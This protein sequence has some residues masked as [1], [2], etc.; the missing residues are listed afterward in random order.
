MHNLSQLFPGIQ[1]ICQGEQPTKEPHFAHN[2]FI[3]PEELLETRKS[4]FLSASMLQ[5][6]ATERF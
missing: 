6:R 1:I 4:P 5:E 3:Q 2:A